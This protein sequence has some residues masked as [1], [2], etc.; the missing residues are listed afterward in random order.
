MQTGV[1][2]VVEKSKPQPALPS[3]GCLSHSPPHSPP[4]PSLSQTASCLCL[5]FQCLRSSCHCSLVS[6][7]FG[8]VQSICPEDSLL[9][10]HPP[11]TPNPVALAFPTY[12]LGL[13]YPPSRTLVPIHVVVFPISL[14]VGHGCHQVFQEVKLLLQL[15]ALF[16]EEVG[17]E[18]VQTDPKH[19][20]GGTLRIAFHVTAPL[21][22]DTRSGELG[23]GYALHLEHLIPLQQ[24][25]P[26]KLAQTPSASH[27]SP[28]R[29]RPPQKLFPALRPLT[30]GTWSWFWHFETGSPG[31]PSSTGTP[32][33]ARAP[34]LR[35]VKENPRKGSAKVPPHAPQPSQP[36]AGYR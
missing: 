32:G 15:N 18:G 19:L 30:G 1:P 31:K 27:H 16:P 23:S 6:G 21:S 13:G 26:T 10:V 7:P 5:C 17:E 35:G 12:I 28:I 3:T 36:V 33:R 34:G 9:L 22:T 14:H 11:A 25:K 24:S 29:T 2:G 20:G 4:V 8:K